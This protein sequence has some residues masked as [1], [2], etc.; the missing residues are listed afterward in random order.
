[1]LQRFHQ[2]IKN[3]RIRAVKSTLLSTPQIVNGVNHAVCFL[4]PF[5]LVTSLVVEQ[6][7]SFPYH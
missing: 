6:R 3:D 7:L 1:M 2:D 5:G 4:I